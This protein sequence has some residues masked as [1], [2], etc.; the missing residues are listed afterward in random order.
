MVAYYCDTVVCTKRKKHF[1]TFS[2]TW[3]KRT[4]P[5]TRL[6]ID[7]ISLDA[8]DLSFSLQQFMFCRHK[9]LYV[10]SSV[11]TNPFCSL[12]SICIPVVAHNW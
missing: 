7:V 11:F 6:C 2:V 1:C 12:G 3:V 4:D 5:I 8:V 9:A 10:Y